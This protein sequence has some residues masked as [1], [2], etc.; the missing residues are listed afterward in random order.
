MLAAIAALLIVACGEDL[1]PSSTPTGPTPT[2]PA[3]A[4]D[5]ERSVT[6]CARDGVALL[7]DVYYP[8]RRADRMPV[9]LF[10]HA[11][12]WVL[13]D[14]LNTGG[15][16]DFGE[17]LARGYVVASIDYGLA[18]DFTFPA[19]IENVKCA[20]RYLRA[21]ASQHSIDPERIGVWGA[22]AGGHLAALLGVTAGD[23]TF[24]GTG[25]HESQSSEVQAVVD[26]FGPADLEATGFVP[27]ADNV[28]RTVFGADGAGPSERLAQF[29]PVRYV[30]T[31]D[32]PFLIIHGDVDGVVPLPQS[33][34]L[35]MKLQEAGVPVILVV[36][37][38]GGHG[39]TPGER[40]MDPDAESIQRIIGDF[41]DA[42]L[43]GDA[44]TMT[45]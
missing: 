37:R 40:P 39:L 33:Q 11:G 5:V 38:N 34:A 15:I 29:S 17:L 6:Y 13:G 21:E 23:E 35:V 41:L 42:H 31:D 7:M 2:P 20:V 36:V 19:Q 22:S 26:L 9:V 24:E 43:R 10:L 8:E 32:P 44:R 4:E 3:R 27:D 16:I 1:E 14:K 30:S 18:P 45:D 25:G 28:A 12:A